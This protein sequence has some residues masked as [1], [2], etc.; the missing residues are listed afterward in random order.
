V[1]DEVDALTTIGFGRTRF[2]V[3]GPRHADHAAVLAVFADLIGMLRELDRSH[4][5]STCQRRCTSAS[6]GGDDDV[7]RS[8]E[9]QGGGVRLLIA[10]VGCL[11][12]F[13]ARGGAERRAHRVDI[14][15]IA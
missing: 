6:C 14:G 3:H 10:G 12:G 9:H 11:R 1:S 4:S 15:R 7:G 5:A 2:L 13:Q 8:S